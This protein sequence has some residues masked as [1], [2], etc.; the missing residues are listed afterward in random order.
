MAREKR[1]TKPLPQLDDVRGGIQD[2][3]TNIGQ[4]VVSAGGNDYFSAQRIPLTIGGIT[5]DVSVTW[6]NLRDADKAAA[7]EAATIEQL[8][9]RLAEL[10]ARQPSS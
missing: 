2:A 6:N 5:G 9:K 1:Y 7:A 3:L 8:R 4:F 10:E